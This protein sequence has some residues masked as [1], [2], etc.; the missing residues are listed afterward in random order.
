MHEFNNRMDAQRRI[1]DIVNG[2]KWQEEL[3]GLSTKGLE[4]W[5]LSNNV[6]AD[7]EL[8]RLLRSASSKLFF[9]ANKSQEQITDDYRAVSR[10]VALLSGDIEKIMAAR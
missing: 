7:S 1:L 8:I 5:A 6:D 10:E 3:F 9:L 2:G 4:R